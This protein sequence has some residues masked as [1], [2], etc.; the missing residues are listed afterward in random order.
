MP[1]R[2]QNFPV[3]VRD[4]RRAFQHLN[5]HFFELKRRH[6]VG[7]LARKLHQVMGVHAEISDQLLVHVPLPD[8]IARPESAMVKSYHAGGGHHV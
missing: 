6:S 3:R 7:R 1:T 5:R 4:R 8:H 2:L